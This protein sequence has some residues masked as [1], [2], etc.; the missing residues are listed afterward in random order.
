MIA[1]LTIV[2]T[3]F[4]GILLVIQEGVVVLLRCDFVIK[5]QIWALDFV[6]D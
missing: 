2:L 6:I 4:L 5:L 3:Q 1:M